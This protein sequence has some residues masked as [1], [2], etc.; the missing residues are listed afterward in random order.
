MAD[1]SRIC[2]R[3]IE[4]FNLSVFYAVNWLLKGILNAESLAILSV[5]NCAF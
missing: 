3:G 1:I 2:C 5:S 4:C